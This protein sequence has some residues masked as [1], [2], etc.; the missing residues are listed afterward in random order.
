[1]SSS[2]SERSQPVAMQPLRPIAAARPPPPLG[3]LHPLR[4]EIIAESALSSLSSTQGSER[5]LIPLLV[6]DL[7]SNLCV[8]PSPSPQS[9]LRMTRSSIVV[10]CFC[11]V[12]TLPTIL[13]PQ[14]ILVVYRVEQG[15]RVISDGVQSWIK[16]SQSDWKCLAFRAIDGLTIEILAPFDSVLID[17]R[18]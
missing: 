6:A 5:P 1:M 16:L 18:I 8:R 14:A 2:A 7:C 13:G 11:F 17:T 15:F 12:V 3:S 10:S 4:T 9:L